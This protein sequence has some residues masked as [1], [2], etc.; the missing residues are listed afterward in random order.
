MEEQ[1]FLFQ[2]QNRVVFT[3]YLFTENEQGNESKW[4]LVKIVIVKWKCQNPLL[5]EQA[6][7]LFTNSFCNPYV[8]GAI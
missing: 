5:I 6:H 3:Y 4:K 7:N 2:L 8:K 1:P